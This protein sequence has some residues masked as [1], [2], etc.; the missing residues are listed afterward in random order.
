ME[1]TN[2][3]DNGIP[4]EEDDYYSDI[5]EYEYEER[6][7]LSL[8]STLQKLKQNDPTVTE[9]GINL[10]NNYTKYFFNIID[11]KE[12]GDCISDNRHLK[13]LHISFYNNVSPD[14]ISR[15]DKHRQQLQDFFSCVYRNSSINHILM[16]SYCI[17]DEFG[18][19]LIQGLCGHCSLTKLE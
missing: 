6:G 2:Q 5:E 9:L 14:F 3:R 18:A 17:L 8:R 15:D 12:D 19:S 7:P 16:Y 13:K 4:M 1:D 10:N 11:W